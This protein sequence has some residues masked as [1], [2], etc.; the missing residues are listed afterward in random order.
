MA[1]A[2]A[3]PVAALRI[4]RTLATSREKV[5]RAWTDPKALAKWFAP[6]DQFRTT[7]PEFQARQGGR[8]NIEMHDPSGQHH[9]VRGTFREVRP[10]ERLVFTW[11]WDREPGQQEPGDTLVT[12]ELF[13]RGG[14]TE[15]VLTHE[16]LPNV[17][18]R[19]KHDHGWAG[20]LG[21]LEKLLAVGL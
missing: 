5:F 6:T 7:V 13:D 15:L 12:V 21:R 9:S 17:E 18:E 10:P 2:P 8:Y 4:T 11:T 14:S 1:T 19:E 3:P 20:C 16:R